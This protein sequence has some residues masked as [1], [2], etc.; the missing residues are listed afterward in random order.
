MPNLACACDS[1][2]NHLAH[3]GD[4]SVVVGHLIAHNPIHSQFD[5]LLRRDTNQLRPNPLIQPSHALALQY[6]STHTH[7]KTYMVKRLRRGSR[8]EYLLEAVKIA[9]VEDLARN[10]ALVL[11]ARLDQVNG[12]HGSRTNRTR[13]RADSKVVDFMENLKEKE[14]K[15]EMNS[16]TQREKEEEIGET[17]NNGTKKQVIYLV[18]KTVVL[19]NFLRL[20][21]LLCGIG[22]EAAQKVA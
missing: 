15:R 17:R 4:V 10:T 1:T 18:S 21:L 8:C 6:L 7:T 20:F 5:G 22:R 13:N 14:N 11:D 2:R 19:K 3:D 9:L 12:V 16:V